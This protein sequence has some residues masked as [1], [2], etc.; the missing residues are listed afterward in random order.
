M[1]NSAILKILFTVEAY[2]KFEKNSS[3]TQAR[4]SSPPF[5]PI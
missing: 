5:Y 1:T 2:I 4:I 3:I